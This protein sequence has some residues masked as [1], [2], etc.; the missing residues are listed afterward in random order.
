M[1]RTV[2]IANGDR[3]C[4]VADDDG[5]VCDATED[6][7][8]TFFLRDTGELSSETGQ[9]GVN[10]CTERLVCDDSYTTPFL[11][12]HD[13]WR[14]GNRVRPHNTGCVE[15]I[16]LPVLCRHH[17]PAVRDAITAVMCHTNI[18]PRENELCI[19][20]AHTKAVS[21]K[22]LTNGKVAGGFTALRDIHPSDMRFTIKDVS[23]EDSP[24]I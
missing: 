8:D 5:V 13:S 24:R 14:W 17:I 6:D 1:E 10:K 18:M 4:R 7:A 3:F 19:V 9:C 12:Q 2:L 11:F 23:T 15:D 20:D 16:G 21:C 22:H